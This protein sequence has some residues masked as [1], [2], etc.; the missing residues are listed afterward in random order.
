M[1][2][3]QVDSGD[4]RIEL[5][6]ERDVVDRPEL[7]DALFVGAAYIV[8]EARIPNVRLAI[9]SDD[10]SMWRL[11]GK[12]VIRVYAGRGAETDQNLSEPLVLEAG[13]NVLSFRLINGRGPARACAHF[14]DKDGEPVVDFAVTLTPPPA[15]AR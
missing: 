13:M 4:A 3:R 9:G 11:N 2:W 12:E 6:S 7:E 14:L 8:C 15:A 5:A 1:L 10:S